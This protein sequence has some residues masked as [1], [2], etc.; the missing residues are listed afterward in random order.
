[1][2][3]EPVL[4]A[5]AR[6]HSTPFYIYAVS[7]GRLAFLTTNLHS[8]QNKL[9]T[10]TPATSWSIGRSLTSG[11]HIAERSISRCHAV[12]GHHAFSNFFITDLGSR[13]R[14]WL[15]GTAVSPHSRETL[16][17]GDVLRFGN[18]S[19]EFFSM[20]RWEK[21]EAIPDITFGDEY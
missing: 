9:S 13:N 19:A 8:G 11:I 4:K 7:L 12:I 1:M 10:T 2:I 15:N 6:C 20:T 14:T 3:I 5:P 17:D 18:V 16:N 21:D